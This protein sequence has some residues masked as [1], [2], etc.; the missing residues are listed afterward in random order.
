MRIITTTLIIVALFVTLISHLL[1][2]TPEGIVILDGYAHGVAMCEGDYTDNEDMFTQEGEYHMWMQH[3]VL[4][5][6]NYGHLEDTEVSELVALA[7]DT[8][9]QYR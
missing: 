2:S 9:A 7:T 3:G 4:Y 1:V 6:I 5:T 8:C